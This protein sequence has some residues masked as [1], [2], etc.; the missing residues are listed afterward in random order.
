MN[1]LTGQHESIEPEIWKVVADQITLRPDQRDR[2][3]AAWKLYGQ[4]LEQAGDECDVI[5]HIRFLAQ[6]G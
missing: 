1:L 4:S 3:E 6:S 5:R 2:V